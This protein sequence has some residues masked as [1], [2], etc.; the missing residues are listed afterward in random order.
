MNIIK[1]TPF[2]LQ[3]L[4]FCRSKT[5][6]N[7]FIAYC[8]DHIHEKILTEVRKAKYFS[9]L[10]DEVADV[11]TTEQLSLMLRFV[12]ENNEIREEFVDFLPCMNGTLGQA[13]ADMILERVRGHQL[14]PVFIHG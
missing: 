11:S 7:D 2:I 12:D 5:I 9:I 13:L 8:G 10:A 14:D 6:Q 3:T 4:V 1:P